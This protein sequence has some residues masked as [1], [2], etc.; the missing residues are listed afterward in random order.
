M[1]VSAPGS[2]A[3]L[4]ARVFRAQC[5]GFELRTPGGTQVAVPKGTPWYAAPSLAVLARQIRAAPPSL[6]GDLAGAGT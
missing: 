4:P 6:P 1:P 3:G 2:P 5:A